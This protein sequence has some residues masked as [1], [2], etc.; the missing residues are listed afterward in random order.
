MTAVAVNTRSTCPCIPVPNACHIW[1]ADEAAIEHTRYPRDNVDWLF[2]SSVGRRTLKSV[3]ALEKRSLTGGEE[4]NFGGE[5][6][7]VGFCRDF[8]AAEG[9]IDHGCSGNAQT[10]QRIQWAPKDGSFHK[11]GKH[12]VLLYG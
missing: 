2:A 7:V 6:L 3:T 10:Y 4:K 8:D 5:T 12:C 9:H 11:C 1:K